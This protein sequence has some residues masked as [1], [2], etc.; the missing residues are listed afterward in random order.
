M[1]PDAIVPPRPPEGAMVDAATGEIINPDELGAA[2]PTDLEV[3]G[4]LGDEPWLHE[5][6]PADGGFDLGTPAEG[7]P[8]VDNAEDI[9]AA[10]AAAAQAEAL[11]RS[12]AAAG[13]A[14]GDD[15][16]LD[17]LATQTARANAVLLR[18]HQALL[19]ATLGSSWMGL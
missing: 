11:A 8:P 5:G 6:V 12:D 17:D 13:T 9:A 2:V 10:N 3:A 16:N 15:R 18:P 19:I 4:T 7:S 14:V 1:D